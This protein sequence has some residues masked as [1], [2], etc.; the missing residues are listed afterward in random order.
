MYAL[1]VWQLVLHFTD[2]I[3]PN[4]DGHKNA[5]GCLLAEVEEC[6]LCLS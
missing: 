6:Q 3:E 1:N 5:H 4:E 2:H